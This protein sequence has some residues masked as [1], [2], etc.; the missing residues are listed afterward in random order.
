MRRSFFLIL[1]ALTLVGTACSDSGRAEIVVL[2]ASSLQGSLDDIAEQWSDTSGVDVVISYAGSQS[3]A[4]QL[5]DGFG[6]D[7]A[8]VA[9]QAIFDQLVDND[10]VDA[11]PELVATSRLVLAFAPG[12]EPR[13]L[14]DIPTSDLILVL[15]DPAVPLGGYSVDALTRAGLTVGE[16]NPAS[17]EVS[18]AGVVTRLRS[19]D[20]DVALI[21]AVDGAGFEVV[22]VDGPS[23][24]YIATPIAGAPNEASN[25]VDHLI[26][27]D[28]QSIWLGAGFDLP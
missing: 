2:A 9:N 6:A 7:V 24:T 21:Y 27:M 28:A 19:G 18:A 16:V 25:F 22:A 26:S 14:T 4:A 20:A 3:L 15:A 11:D 1:T 8:V 17:L 12:V 23:T 13:D 5:R 10:V